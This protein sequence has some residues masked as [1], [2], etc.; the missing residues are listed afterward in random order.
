MHSIIDQFRVPFRDDSVP[1]MASKTAL[2]RYHRELDTVAT[3]NTLFFRTLCFPLG[4][5]T[6]CSPVMLK[7]D[8]LLPAPIEKISFVSQP[9]TRSMRGAIIGQFRVSARNDL[10][11]ENGSQNGIKICV[12]SC[13]EPSETLL[14][15]GCRAM[16][17]SEALG[18]V[19]GTPGTSKFLLPPQCGPNFR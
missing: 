4:N 12:K 5:S 10:G 11:A 2:I 6:F 18:S 14:E 16:R 9:Q 7:L 1:K 15:P 13:Q 19:L 17:F 3:R 8:A